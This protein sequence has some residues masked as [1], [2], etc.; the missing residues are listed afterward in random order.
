MTVKSETISLFLASRI[1]AGDFPSAVYLV[2]DNGQPV[3]A[4][5][6]GHAVCEPELHAATHETIYDLASLTKP[7][8]TAL[9]CALMVERKALDMEKPVGHYLE[10]FKNADKKEITVRQLLT[11]SSGLKAW[12]PLKIITDCDCK[13]T[14]KV[15][16]DS[17]LEA[18]AAQR[19]IY[20]DLGFIVLGKLIEQIADAKLDGVAAKNI[21][22]PLNLQNTFFNP[23]HKLRPQIAASEKGNFYEREMAT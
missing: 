21:F 13:R 17:E 9:L 11:H 6:L 5:A 22:E 18:A 16:A 8:I 7:F 3:F 4:D 15:I 12:L 19:V 23:Q 2:A 10:E 1:E 20:S 14:L